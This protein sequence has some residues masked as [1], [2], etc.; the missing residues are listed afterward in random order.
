M[1]VAAA[2]G[3][4][5]HIP[6]IAREI[7]KIE[8]CSHSHR[9]GRVLQSWREER[10]HTFTLPALLRLLRNL[11]LRQAEMWVRILSARD[12]QDY[13]SSQDSLTAD[14]GVSDLTGS[15][16]SVSTY[17]TGPVITLIVLGSQYENSV[18]YCRVFVL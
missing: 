14:S 3:L 12:Y 8:S 9:L 6:I 11:E 4:G 18:Y 17:R 16:S 5:H 13:Y 10:P 1:E 2:L 15:T 7:N